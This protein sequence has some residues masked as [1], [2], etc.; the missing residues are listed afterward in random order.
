MN[1]NLGGVLAL[2]LG[3]VDVQV[4]FVVQYWLLQE[5]LSGGLEAEFDWD[6]EFFEVNLDGE[7]MV[8]V[9]LVWKTIKRLFN[10]FK[11]IVFT[12]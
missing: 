9:R 7:L 3:R 8:H 2:V 4:G 5:V 6:V 10:V 11:K 1:V 12:V